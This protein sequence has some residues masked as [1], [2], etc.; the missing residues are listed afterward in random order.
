MTC[1]FMTLRERK[2][3]L[4][5]DTISEL[6]DKVSRPGTVVNRTCNCLILGSLENSFTF[7]FGCFYSIMK[8]NNFKK[9]I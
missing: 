3:I 6:L 5:I 4:E 2:E 7:P 1:R 8:Y 9:E